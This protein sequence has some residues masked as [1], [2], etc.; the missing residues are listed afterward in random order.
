MK[1]D[2]IH[3]PDKITD[4]DDIIDTPHPAEPKALYQV[5]NEAYKRRVET[6][7]REN[8]HHVVINKLNTNQPITKSEIEELERILFDGGERGTKDRYTNVYQNEPLGTFIR[9]IV[10]LD[11]KTAQD[12]FA[13]FLQ[14]GNLNADQINFIQTIIKYLNVNGTIDKTLLDQPPF[15]DAHQEGIFGLFDTDQTVKLIRLIDEVNGNAEGR[16]A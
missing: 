1:S 8:K 5:N 4:F 11:I 3:I 6:F 10:G 14:T 7:V 15:D 16:S 2:G 13:Q 12:H 9:G